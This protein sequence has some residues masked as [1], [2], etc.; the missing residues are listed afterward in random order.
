[1]EE[2]IWREW[3]S[4][5]YGAAYDASYTPIYHDSWSTYEDNAWIYILEKDSQL[6]ILEYSYSP[7]SEDSTPVWDL[8]PVTEEYAIQEMIEWEQI[9]RD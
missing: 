7:F 5:A 6:Y 2:H 4:E 1:M 9:H 8:E 3:L